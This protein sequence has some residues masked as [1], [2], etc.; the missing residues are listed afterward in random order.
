MS[1]TQHV[2]NVE[3]CQSSTMFVNRNV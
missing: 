3:P 2:V 1:L